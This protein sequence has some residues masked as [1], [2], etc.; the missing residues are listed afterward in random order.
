MLF[1]IPIVIDIHGHRF[2]ILTL[3]LEIHE[4][5]NLVLSMINTFVLEGIINS[6]ESCF[7][8][9]NRLIPFFQKEPIILRPKK[10]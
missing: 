3:V 9:L 7:S 6:Q 2:E 5:V 10:Q 1:I 8:F 4:N